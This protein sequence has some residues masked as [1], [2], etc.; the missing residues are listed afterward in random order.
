MK[1][2][3]VLIIFNRPDTTQRV[4]KMIQQA[5]PKQLL[6]IADGPRDTKLGEEQACI[7]AQKVIKHIDWDCELNTNFSTTNLG[8]KQRIS[9]GL[10]WAFSLVEE[11]IILE[12]DCCPNPTFFRYCEELLIHY[13]NDTRIT[14]ICG[15]NAQFGREVTEHSYYFSRYFHAWGWATWRR[16]WQGYD[17]HMRKWPE[18]KKT[19]EFKALFADVWIAKYWTEIFDAV[20]R[21]DVQTWDYQWMFYS[22]IQSGLSIIPRENL[23]SN[24]GFGQQS[25]H[26]NN[27]NSRYSNVSTSP[28]EFPLNHN[29]FVMRNVS[30]DNYEEL[31]KFK[32]PSSLQRV[33]KSLKGSI[34]SALTSS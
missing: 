8:C 33:R 29:P 28:L 34:K 10:D 13:R 2:P 15:E 7:E 21:G 5:K 14:A 4:F 23:I 16:A 3:I 30:A 31:T 19:A 17:V 20:H 24:L 22:F 11:A 26:T 12:D 25:T 32:V 1:T 6:V 27:S 18:I 9:S